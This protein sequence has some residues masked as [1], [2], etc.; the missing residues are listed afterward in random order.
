MRTASAG[1]GLVRGSLVTAKRTRGF[2]LARSVET[3]KSIRPR[4]QVADHREPGKCRAVAP[5][6][7]P[8]LGCVGA[9]IQVQS[10]QPERLQLWIADPEDRVVNAV[11]VNLQA[12]VD[13]GVGQA[14]AVA[15][16]GIFGASGEQ[17]AKLFSAQGHGYAGG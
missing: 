17:Q 7:A 11:E 14:D 4:H 2:I 16:V 12:G 3:E 13:C 1:R 9:S 10:A 8:A 15:E 6:E 5:G